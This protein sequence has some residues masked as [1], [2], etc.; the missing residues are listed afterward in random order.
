MEFVSEEHDLLVTE[1]NEGLLIA[2]NNKTF[3][4][5]KKSMQR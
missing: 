3:L 2:Q 1:Q 4:A 5:R